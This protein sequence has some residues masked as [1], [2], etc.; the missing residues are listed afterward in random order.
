LYKPMGSV[1]IKK[2][3]GGRK[4]RGPILINARLSKQETV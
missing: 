1:T 4:A 2:G 3:Q